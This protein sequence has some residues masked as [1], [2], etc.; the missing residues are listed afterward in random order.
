MGELRTTAT[1]LGDLC[2]VHIR[3]PAAHMVMDTEHQFA[4]LGRHFHE[5]RLRGRDCEVGRRALEQPHRRLVLLAELARLQSHAG[6]YSP[7]FHL[8]RLLLGE[9]RERL[10]G[11]GVR[12]QPIHGR[13]VV[14][15]GSRMPHCWWSRMGRIRQYSS[16]V[17]ADRSALQPTEWSV[18]PPRHQRPA[19]LR[20]PASL[21][22]NHA[23]REHGYI[24]PFLIP[25]HH[26]L[27]R[28]YNQLSAR[29][30]Y[31]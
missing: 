30:E 16:Q 21:Q 6:S 19:N 7:Q 13:A 23:E 28:S 22:V 24:E 2:N 10:T 5:K 12:H 27:E 15:L 25:D 26:E 14:H 29:W 1:E 9:G 20:Q 3:W 11:N 17:G 4:F 8:R 18:E 31:N